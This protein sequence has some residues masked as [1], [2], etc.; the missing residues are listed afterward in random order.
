MR[1]DRIVIK[2][3]GS[4]GIDQNAV[5]DDIAEFVHS[6]AG[7][8]VVHGGSDRANRLAES[9]GHRPVFL[10]SPTGHVSR[11]T[12]KETRDIFVRATD[13]L[14]AEIV[15]ALEARQ[16]SPRALIHGASALWGER[17]LAIR[18]V[19]GGKTRVIRDDYSGRITGVDA[20]QLETLLQEGFVPV[21]PPVARSEADG[22]L[23]VDGDRAAA[24]VAAAVEADQLIIISNVSGLL[25]HYPIED[26][27]VAHV[28]Q[29]D[30]ERAMG[31]AQ[32]RMKRKVMSVKAALESGVRR[33][34]LADG[35]V[36]HPLRQALAGGGTWFD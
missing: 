24:A 2:I 31:W 9:I 20:R 21:L 25:Q 6:G 33:V 8:I 23:N 4:T 28:T 16:V 30:L 13:E 22:L 3:G 19:E 32:G 12:D 26:S 10:T 18:S 14:N 27:L 1:N 29:E 5:C 7:V 15:A 17:K 11:Y 34:A 36:A 35:R